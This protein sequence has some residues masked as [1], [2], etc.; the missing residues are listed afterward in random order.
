[1]LGA[2]IPD[3]LSFTMEALAARGALVEREKTGSALALLPA[4]IAS[5]LVLQEECRLQPDPQAAHRAAEHA[6]NAAAVPIVPCGLGTPLL[7]RLVG[8]CRSERPG[9]AVRL[10]VEP[11]NRLHARSLGQRF[12][13]RNGLAD[14]IEVLPGECVYLVVAVAYVAE[15]DDRHE[16]VVSV[17][18][19]AQ[20]G[21]APDEGLLALLDIVSPACT[22]RDDGPLFSC[23]AQSDRIQPPAHLA[24]WIARRAEVAVR[25]AV[26]PTLESVTR[27]H[28]RD[29]ARI[30][31]YFGQ[32]AA[33]ARSPRRRVDAAALAARLDH[34]AAERDGKLRDLA[35]RFALRVALAPA[36]LVRVSVPSVTI[37]LHVRRRKAAGEIFVRLPA[38]ARTLDR[39]ACAGCL[40]ATSQ[41]ALC[42]DRLHTLCESCAPSS[43]GRPRCPACSRSSSPS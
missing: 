25:L 7:E 11:P 41:P 4:E 42:D 18:L 5:A 3:P 8:D 26:R 15:A 34:L 40:D 33:E 38:G 2:E 13:V 6:A 20:D 9:A 1:M 14:V 43:A 21:G 16:G 35:A 29:H 36:A 32:L 28:A 37:H 23:I 10:E 31:E 39:V 30:V 17:C 24:R 27:R 12:V 22:L 19:S